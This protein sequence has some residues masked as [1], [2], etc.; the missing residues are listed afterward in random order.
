MKDE[1]QQVPEPSPTF[2]DSEWDE[3]MRWRIARMIEA[4]ERIPTL[5]ELLTVMRNAIQKTRCV[6]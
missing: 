5:D 1:H 2:T 3:V 4:D 6:R